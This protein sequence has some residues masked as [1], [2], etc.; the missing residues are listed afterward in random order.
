MTSWDIELGEG[1]G[2]GYHLGSGQGLGGREIA[3]LL[4]SGVWALGEFHCAGIKIEAGGVLGGI[5]EPQLKGGTGRQGAVGIYAF[6]EGGVSNQ[7]LDGGQDQVQLLTYLGRDN[8]GVLHSGGGHKD[9]GEETGGYDEDGDVDQEF[10]E[11]EA[12]SFHSESLPYS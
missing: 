11:G 6:Y 1:E 10:D 3:V 7:T 5:F 4:V 8:L 12:F 9:G 2:V